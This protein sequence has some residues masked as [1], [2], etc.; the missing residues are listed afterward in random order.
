L[1]SCLPAGPVLDAR[2][3][4]AR[5]V[6][7][8]HRPGCVVLSKHSVVVRDEG[9]AVASVV[10]LEIIMNSTNNLLAVLTLYFRLILIIFIALVSTIDTILRH[11][12]VI[13]AFHY[14][15]CSSFNKFNRSFVTFIIFLVA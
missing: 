13:L 10:V 8:L 4:Q 7:Q 15:L 5:H 14:R 3:L 11:F 1:F 9:A 12:F 2:L 6:L